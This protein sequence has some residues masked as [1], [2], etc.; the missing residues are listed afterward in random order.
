MWVI[1]LVCLY[2]EQLLSLVSKLSNFFVENYEGKSKFL[3]TKLCDIVQIFHYGR[4]NVLT[5]KMAICARVT[6]LSGQ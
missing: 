1:R 5:K 6:F 4:L 3:F 2:V